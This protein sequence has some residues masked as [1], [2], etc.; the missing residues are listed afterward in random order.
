MLVLIRWARLRAVTV[1]YN[2][3][4]SSER[5]LN[6]TQFHLCAQTATMRDLQA[7]IHSAQILSKRKVILCLAS[8][9]QGNAIET[10]HFL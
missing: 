5:Y 2:L 7:E 1:F 9:L 6:I 10:Y 8:V 4:V 3:Y